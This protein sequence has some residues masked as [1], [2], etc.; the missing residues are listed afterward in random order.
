MST[1]W[2]N[3]QGSAWSHRTKTQQNGYISRS[4]YLG[5][6]ILTKNITSYIINQYSLLLWLYLLK[7]CRNWCN[8][9]HICNLSCITT[10]VPH[11]HH[12]CRPTPV[13]SAALHLHCCLPL[14]NHTSW[15]QICIRW[16]E[17][18]S[19]SF[20]A[21]KCYYNA[22]NLCALYNYNIIY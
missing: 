5:K 22:F 21:V 19:S 16:D 8:C 18:Q 6:S 11:V 13:E 2:H 3:N 17:L 15:H 12:R 20:C 14:D 4:I 9:D 10:W 7:Y 1:S